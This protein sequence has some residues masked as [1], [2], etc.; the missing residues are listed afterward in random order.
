MDDGLIPV[1][2]AG[3]TGRMGRE[4]A[5]TIMSQADME[6]A[7][8][9]GHARHLGED[10]GEL[11]MG[12]PCGIIVTPEPG[13]VFEKAAGGVL[14]DVSVGIAVK[15]TVLE[16]LKHNIACVV[17]ATSIPAA[18]IDEMEKAAAAYG[19]PVLIAPNF[20]LGAVLMMKF[21]KI[22]ARYFRWAEIIELHHERK[23]DAPSGT[24]ARTAEMM[25][26]AR[27]GGFRSPAEGEETVKGVRGGNMGGIRIHSVRMPGLLAHQEVM[28]GNTGEVLHIR[29]DASG[30]ECFMSGVVL[31]VQKVRALT[32]LVTG[33]ENVLDV[34][35]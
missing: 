17:G 26:R 2:V 34:E 15:D 11:V 31:A 32:G 33:L 1:V 6:L 3:A 9:L 5:R 22:A 14:V 27:V 4:I 18:D 28:L 24:A 19:C 30:R 25:L 8:A 7:G 35:E 23:L 16:A 20:A 29:H 21:S 12:E 10:I 13:E